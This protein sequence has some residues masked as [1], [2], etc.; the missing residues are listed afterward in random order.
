MATETGVSPKPF[1]VALGICVSS[2][3]CTPVAH[4]STIL[5]MGPGRYQFKHYLQIGGVIAFLTWLL[6]TMVTPLV[7]RF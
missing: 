5:V 1:M 3:F 4:E 2:G 7:W 6:A